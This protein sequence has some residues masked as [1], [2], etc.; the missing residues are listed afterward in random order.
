V[1]FF[2]MW[3]T[4]VITFFTG[5][6]GQPTARDGRYFLNN[7]GQETEIS[8][9]EYDRA[10]SQSTRAFAAGAAVFY[11]LAATASHYGPLINQ[12]VGDDTAST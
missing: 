12:Q 1:F 8:L 5:A 7:H 3:L 10:V 6:A 9:E 11:A 4:M 2:A